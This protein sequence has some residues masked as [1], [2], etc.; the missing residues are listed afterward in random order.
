MKCDLRSKSSQDV[1]E[2]KLKG[3]K[4]RKKTKIKKF[5]SS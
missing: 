2:Q 4:W 5:K 3:F 1:R